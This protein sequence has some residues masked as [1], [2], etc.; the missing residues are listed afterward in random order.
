MNLLALILLLLSA[1]LA[2]PRFPDRDGDGFG[3]PPLDADPAVP[4]VDDRDDCDDLDGRVFPEAAEGW[5]DG[6]V[7]NDCDDEVEPVFARLRPAPA[8]RA[9]PAEPRADLDGDGV[10]DR[11]EADG[12]EARVISGRTGAVLARVERAARARLV[13]DVDGDG[14]PDLVVLGEEARFHTALLARPR[15]RAS[16]ARAVVRGGP[17]TAALDLGDRDHD[18]RSETLLAA[19][20]GPDGRGWVGV[21]CAHDLQPGLVA[22]ALTLQARLPAGQGEGLAWSAAGSLLVRGASGGWSTI[23]PP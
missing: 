5:G 16:E 3:A 19:A 17:F 21:V 15:Q 11:V 6:F 7:D 8:P 22:S 4:R 13:G 23:P 20:R 18:G 9:R 1:V 14:D 12:A 10:A 2:A